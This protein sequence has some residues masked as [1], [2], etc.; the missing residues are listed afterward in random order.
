V[1][2]PDKDAA[3]RPP[4]LGSDE[5]ARIF[6]VE[7]FETLA[8]ERMHPSAYAYIRGWAGSGW[9]ARQNSLAYRHWVLRPRALVDVS[10]LDVS[11]TVLGTPISVPIMFAPTSIHRIAH[12][13]GELATARAAKRI[14]TLQVL[15]T[16]ASTKFEDV[17]A[18][19]QK[20]WFQLY[21][22]N[23]RE[24][25]RWLVERAHAAGFGAIVLTVDAPVEYWREDEARNPVIRPSGVGQPNLPTDR[26]LVYD[27]TL[28]WKSLEWLRS[29]SPLPIVLKGI[30]RADDAS[31]AAE[32]GASGIIVSNHGGRELDTSTPTLEALPPIVKAVDGRIEVYVDGGVR[33]GTDVLKAL[34][35]GARA[36]LVGRQIQ[37]ALATGGEPGIVR[38]L[39]LMTGEFTSAM[40]LCGA[41]NVAEI[42]PAIVRR[43]LD[44]AAWQD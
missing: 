3:N 32:H 15:S 17:A 28:T 37:W 8:A 42:T 41:R 6:S 30:L 24:I 9:T 23:D 13:E 25:T 20:R 31:L 11:T 39:E 16:G 36:V 18:V 2:A 33:R 43:N 35:L 44:R 34:A 7:E 1:T 29:V 22:F 5:L 26:N 12:P 21:W 38:L 19:G 40:A 10:R 14:D 27:P 4:Y